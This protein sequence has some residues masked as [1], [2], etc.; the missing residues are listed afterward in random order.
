[1]SPRSG[2][3]ADARAAGRLLRLVD[4]EYSGNGDP[5]FEVGNT[6]RELDY[7]DSLSAESRTPMAGPGSSVPFR[8]LRSGVGG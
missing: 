6:W 8:D 3:P 5:A 2:A 7:D 4:W 1:M